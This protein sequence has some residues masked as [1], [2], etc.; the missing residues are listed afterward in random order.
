MSTVSIYRDAGSS[1]TVILYGDGGDHE[2]ILRDLDGW[3]GSPESKVQLSERAYGN[4]AHDIAAGDV[5]YGARTV[6]VDWRII[7]NGRDGMLAALH[8][9][10]ALAGHTVIVRVVDGMDDL[11]A[12]GYVHEAGKDKSA[13]NIPQQTET[14]TLTIV[15]QRPEI[16]S[17][18]ASESQ[19]F[20]VS[21]V[22]GG[23]SYGPE[24]KG[25]S[26][27]PDGRGLS[28][29]VSAEGERNLMIVGNRGTTVSYPTITV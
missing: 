21:R 7:A 22:S 11:Y 23:L 2:M 3:Y 15:C 5:D 29:G 4:G 24:G 26:Y 27:G 6:M 14:G 9:I 20:P 18:S 12:V 8:A 17:W 13:Q 25:L 28:Y 10:R 1:P 16:L 19:L